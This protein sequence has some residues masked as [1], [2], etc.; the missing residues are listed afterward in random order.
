MR[1][2]PWTVCGYCAVAI[3]VALP[4]FGLRTAATAVGPDGSPV[5]T[6]SR[7]SAAALDAGL[8]PVGDGEDENVYG[9]H[10]RNG[11]FCGERRE[12][13]TVNVADHP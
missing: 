4:F 3:A 6:A 9:K 11:I 8:G 13:L 7:V 1:S 2:P 10:L 5:G 12:K